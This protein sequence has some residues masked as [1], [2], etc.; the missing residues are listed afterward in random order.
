MATNTGFTVIQ[1]IN[2]ELAL[3]KGG[4]DRVSAYTAR[5]IRKQG[6]GGRW[7]T[8]ALTPTIREILWPLRGHHPESVFTFVAR[9]T[10]PVKGR[11]R[12][13]RYPLTAGGV[14]AAWR[15]LRD[16]AGITGFRFHDFRHD[17]ATKLLRATGNLKLVQRALNHADI[18]TTVRYAHVLDHEVAEA[19]EHVARS[20][21]ASRTKLREVS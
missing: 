9:R 2:M 7:V 15:R 3:Y 21:K 4:S 8:V 17:F 13:Q 19:M 1:I 5:Q 10:G 6:K 20:R 16:R 12:G 11:I 14:R 18:A